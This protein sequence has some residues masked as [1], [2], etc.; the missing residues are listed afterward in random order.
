MRIEK[1]KG[2]GFKSL[3]VGV[4]EG[5]LVSKQMRVSEGSLALTTFKG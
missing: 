1:R 3:V 2:E 4:S 5:R